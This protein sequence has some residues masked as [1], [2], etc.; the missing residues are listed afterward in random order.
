MAP[1]DLGQHLAL[2][3]TGMREVPER[4][5]A[6]LPQPTRVG[7]DPERP[8]WLSSA[9]TPTATKAPGPGRTTPGPRNCLAARAI[10]MGC[11]GGEGGVPVV[12][13]GP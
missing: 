5:C 1:N 3:A 2:F 9:T 6:D 12:G 4:L 10:R 8:G 7:T 11:L 13:A